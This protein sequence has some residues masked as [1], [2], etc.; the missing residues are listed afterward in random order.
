[1]WHFIVLVI[2]KMELDLV[3]L[4]DADKASRDVPSE[5]P[6]HV[7][8]AI[9]QA[10]NQFADFEIDDYFGWCFPGD[11]RGDSGCLGE[12]GIFDIRWRRVDFGGI[13]TWVGWRGRRS[14]RDVR[15]QGQ[16]CGNEDSGYFHDFCNMPDVLRPGIDLGHA[17]LRGI[18]NDI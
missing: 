15:W 6:E 8:D 18:L 3:T 9:G 4:A 17:F 2:V 11:G 1:M 12:D 7:L 5:S 16:E 14:G 10:M 13:V